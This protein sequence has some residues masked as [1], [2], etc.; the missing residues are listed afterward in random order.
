[1]MN[2][3]KI[4]P[5]GIFTNYIFKS[6]PLAFDESLSY[7]EVLCGVLDKLKTQEEVINNNADLLAEL[8]SYV[9][10]YFDN[11]DVQEEINNKL[12]EMAEDGTLENLISQYISLQTTY[13]YNNVNEMK[14]A[15]NL[16]N[17]SF[18]RTS[19]YYE[20]NDGGGAYYKI[21]NVTNNDDIDEMF[22]IALADTSLVAELIINDELNIKQIG[23]KGLIDT[24]DTLKIKKACE[25]DYNLYFPK[26][27]YYLNEQLIIFNA[28]NRI[29]RG[30]GIQNTIFKISNNQTGNHTSYITTSSFE[31]DIHNFIIKD[32]SINCGTQNV[33][34]YG[35]SLLTIDNLNLEN[36]EIYN[37]KGYATRFNDSTN[38]TA[39]NLYLHDCS[40]PVSGDGVAGGFYGQNMKNVQINNTKIINCGD[41]A[42][43]LSG[44]V[45]GSGT[46][47]AENIQLNNVY[48]KNIGGDGYTAGGAITIYGNIKN[49]ELNNCIVENSREG[50]HI[51][52]H[53]TTLITPKDI[54]IANCIIKNSVNSGIYLQGL[55]TDLIKDVNIVNCIIDT[56]NTSDGI[57]LRQCERISVIGNIIKNIKRIGIEIINTDNSIINNNI[58]SNNFA[59]LYCGTRGSTHAK[60]NT[61]SNNTVFTTDDYNSNN[62]NNSGIFINTISTNTILLNNNVYNHLSYNFLIRGSTNKSILQSLNNKTT[63]FTRNILYG[64]NYPT[65]VT[66]SE[67]GDICLNTNATA[68]GNIG[69]VCT[70][71]GTPGTWK[72]FGTIS[73]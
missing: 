50:I 16:S 63:N 22:I 72:A 21:R 65:T 45:A 52:N 35:L 10:N 32:L 23:V 27:T 33:N 53:G 42:F 47:Y 51:S 6:I 66:D 36:I 43:Y 40:E 59:E 14:Q 69:W 60:N 39:T 54:T 31:E 30:D 71:A 41:H 17:G 2:I 28:T 15:T 19:G 5:S 56:T 64:D 26:G 29:I 49:V 46:T 61:I 67:V 55:E 44:D 12:D 25:K 73:S 68:G 37:N 62:P 58:L 8:E 13:T 18:T 4:K 70:V 57:S 48:C 3:Q 20:Y 7:Y 38:I 9:K 34:R 24:D 1:M 11:L